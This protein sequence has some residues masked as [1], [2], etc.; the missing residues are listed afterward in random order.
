M[1]PLVAATIATVALPSL[2]TTAEEVTLAEAMDS[3]GLTWTT[4]ESSPFTGLDAVD[5][6]E[7]GDIARG[8]FRLNGQIPWGDP[9]NIWMETTVTGPGILRLYVRTSGD[10]YITAGLQVDGVDVDSWIPDYQ[11]GPIEPTSWQAMTAGIRPGAH[12]VRIYGCFAC[13]DIGAQEIFDP[14]VEV[15]K[16][17]LLPLNPSLGPAMNTTGQLWY[18]GGDVFVSPGA[19]A[20]DGIGAIGLGPTPGNNWVETAIE[21]PATASWWRKG[22]SQ[23]RIDDLAVANGEVEAWVQE[24]YFIPA[25]ETVIRWGQLANFTLDEFSAQPA[26]AITL[27]EALD[28]NLILSPGGAGTWSGITSSVAPDGVDMAYLEVTH[29][30]E[31]TWLE[32]TVEGPAAL[33]YAFIVRGDVQLLVTDNGVPI[34]EGRDLSATE[35]PNAH[36]TILPAGTHQIRLETKGSLY[37]STT[38]AVLMLDQLK[39]TP[40]QD[41]SLS[42]ALDAPNLTWTTG[43]DRIWTGVTSSLAPDGQDAAVS[44][45]LTEGQSAW[46]ETSVTGPG[47][48]SFRWKP[49]LEGY[50]DRRWKFLV[51]GEVTTW[52]NERTSA[53]VD[54]RFIELGPGEHSF[55]W[56]VEGPAAGSALLLDEITWTPSAQPPLSAALDTQ[57]FKSNWQNIGWTV[58][59]GEGLEGG[60]AL[61]FGHPGSFGHL[62]DLTLH[63]RGPSVVRF[64]AKTGPRCSLQYRTNG[65]ASEYVTPGDTWTQHSIQIPPGERRL[66]LIPA[67]WWSEV[68]PETNVMIDRLSIEPNDLRPSSVLP[69]TAP[70]STWTTSAANPWVG[71]SSPGVRDLVA[72]GPNLNG[73]VSWLQTTV[74]GPAVLKFLAKGQGPATRTPG[75]RV[76]VNGREART[77]NST[78]HLWVVLYFPT[79][80]HQLRLETVEG[81][82]QINPEIL[83]FDYAPMAG[84]PTVRFVGNHLDLHVPRP[85]GYTDSM[86]EM[87]SSE[88]I[89]RLGYGWSKN[90]NATILQSTPQ[91]LIL[92]YDRSLNPLPPKKFFAAAGFLP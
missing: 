50:E 34:G 49:G 24:H 91:R 71:V 48:F 85:R 84:E 89:D 36:Q 82:I 60:D 7:D 22:R 15:D 64:Y 69:T 59:A 6:I 87:R 31:P 30:E 1:S 56:Q 25:G 51:D 52:V 74:R 53:A 14:A 77:I 12:T 19:E 10:P 79:G 83:A 45:G 29:G 92:R 16:L 18:S 88:H 75:A 35:S 67:Y 27:G 42:E 3:P 43:G 38:H 32:F 57:A 65:V 41:V 78:G 39:V 37:P 20:H 61:R 4:S 72:A 17:E 9:F 40:L 70:N 66:D 8:A 81:H 54:P 21:G 46:L 2:R 90:H 55:Q 5:A 86:I 73:G 62:T 44:P 11:F 23:I 76:L 68:D 80:D 26:T 28:T 47:T 63:V 13:D 33:E 58:A